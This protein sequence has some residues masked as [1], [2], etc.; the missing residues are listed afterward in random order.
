MFKSGVQ[1]GSR[2]AAGII[3]DDSETLGVDNL[4]FE[5][6]GPTCGTA[7]RRGTS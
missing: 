1:L 2:C 7:D 6:V 5:L 3:T 4:K